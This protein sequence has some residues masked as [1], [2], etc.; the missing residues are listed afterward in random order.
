MKKSYF[1]IILSV[2]ALLRTVSAFAGNCIYCLEQFDENDIYCEACKVKLSI[3]DLKSK[4]A[5]LVKILKISRENYK[6]ALAELE[7]FY[8]GIGNRLRSNNVRTELKALSKVPQALYNTDLNETETD[9]PVIETGK[10]SIEEA[11]I[12][13]FDAN[14]YRNVLPGIK[15]ENSLN[16]AAERYKRIIEKYPESDKAS[17]AAYFLAEI[18]NEPSFSA[19]E[20]A[21]SLYVKCYEEDHATDKPALYKAALT[22]DYKL[23]NLKE[24]INY[25]K[26]AAEKSLGEKYQKRAKRR[27]DE[28]KIDY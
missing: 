17:D 8:L 28:L 7:S 24:A 3:D 14:S 18:Y 4:E 12:L 22:Y 6:K 21:A 27:L 11:D 10:K 5:K 1:L 23:D 9:Q 15:R 19:Y 20:N 13:F 26:L 25:Y 2:F 16:M